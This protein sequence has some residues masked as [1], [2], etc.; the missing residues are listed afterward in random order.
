[1]LRILV[2]AA[3]A[4]DEALG[5]G[6]T[7]ARHAHTGD[8]IRI[9]FMTDGEGA[10]GSA[11]ADVPRR[12]AASL[13]AAEIMGAKPPVHFDF[14]DNAMDSVPRIH[15]VQAIEAELASF[16]PD[17]VYTHHAHDLNID[18]R[19]THEAV[20]TAL[21]PQ[22]HALSPTILSF[23]VM[24]STEWQTPGAVTAFVP[25][26][27]VDIGAF[28]EVKKAALRAYHDEMRPWPHSRSIEALEYLARWRG[29]CVGLTAAE[30]FSLVRKLG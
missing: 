29:A 19:I 13:A 12:Q 10:R 1:M 22:P 28:L 26:W 25:N 5:C 23:E 17:I 14:P 18:H 27:H 8:S 24:S 7:L 6:G 20:V 4:D 30:A 15:I 9:L 11:V 2:V 16:A 3:H 21:R